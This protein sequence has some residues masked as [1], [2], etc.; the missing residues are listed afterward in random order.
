MTKSVR[1]V[2]DAG[3]ALIIVLWTLV[4]VTLLVTQLL[5][6]GRSEAQLAANIRGAAAVQAA[7]DGSLQQ[8]VFHLLDQTVR[9]WPADGT[10]HT[11]AI[12]G[13][14]TLVRIDN[15]AGK[16]NPNSAPAGLLNALL[17]RVGA[18]TRTAATVA[19]A[20]AAWRSPLV[21]ASE[22]AALYKAAGHD[23]LPPDAPFQSLD[24]LG[25]VLGM[26]P[27]LLA[28]VT[29]FMSLYRNGEPDSASAAPLVR[30]ALADWSGAVAPDTN[31]RP[32]ETLV[33]ITATADVAGKVRA[34]R[35]AVVEIVG[36]AD[37]VPYRILSWQ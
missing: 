11:L 31:K 4:L 26:T 32:D 29:P 18:D 19:A 9:H 17:R 7:A 27:S 5:A 6:A 25:L 34:T 13:I 36:T 22:Q 15:E 3:F 30:A 28:R 10:S 24:E 21:P 33:T 8:A 14:N 12:A 16:I 37:A 1:G 20:I 2:L 23:Y 35:R